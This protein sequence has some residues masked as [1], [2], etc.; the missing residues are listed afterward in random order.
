M[1]DKTASFSLDTRRAATT[2]RDDYERSW[3]SHVGDEFP[4][5]RFSAA[6]V[7]DFRVRFR[8]ARL[9]DVA[10]TI[11]DGASAA[12]TADGPVQDTETSG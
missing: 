2:G 12:R 4:L 9:H 5:P 3:H 11:V 10:L 8:A 7:A 1:D 6:T